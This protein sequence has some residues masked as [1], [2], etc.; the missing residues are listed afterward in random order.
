M[1][2]RSWGG[3]V[4]SIGGKEVFIKAVLQAILA[5]AMSCFLLP[6]S[7]CNEINSILSNY[8]WKQTNAS[9]GIHWF[10]W[11][12]ICSTKNK[13]GMGF[14]DMAKFNIAMVAKQGWRLINTRNSLVYKILKAKYFSKVSLLESKLVHNPSLSWRSIWNA[15][16]MLKKG[17][18]WRV[19][20]ERNIR[21]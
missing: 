18:R 1:L 7:L 16:E 4:L 10:S 21:I 14:R 8:W 17:V 6:L 2:F 13:E 3:R 19:G 20:N 15:L 12:K 11:K 5:Y 9:K